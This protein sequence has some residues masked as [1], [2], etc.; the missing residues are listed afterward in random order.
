MLFL[1]ESLNILL[2]RYIAD[3]KGNSRKYK[4][5]RAGDIVGLQI[6]FDDRVI[7]YYVNN[8]WQTSRSIEENI[9]QNNNKSQR[10]YP[11]VSMNSIGGSV[12]L[13]LRDENY[14][15]DKHSHNPRAHNRH[16]IK[17]I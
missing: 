9:G 1:K 6:D 10:L 2:T 16:K 17:L 7:D 15:Q 3:G 5:L 4:L 11:V 13:H 12:S 14:N 8:R